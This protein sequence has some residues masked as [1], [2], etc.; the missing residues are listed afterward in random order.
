MC[1]YLGFLLPVH[2]W[3]LPWQPTEVTGGVALSGEQAFS[4]LPAPHCGVNGALGAGCSG[5]VLAVHLLLSSCH[6]PV[7]HWIF[8]THL[9]G[10]HDCADQE[11]ETMR[12]STTVP[13]AQFPWQ[14]RNPTLV[15]PL[16]IHALW[17]FALSMPFG[18][19]EQCRGR[20][21]V[22]ISPVTKM[23][24]GDL[25]S[26][27]PRALFILVPFCATFREGSAALFWRKQFQETRLSLCVSTLCN[28]KL[29]F[30]YIQKILSY[31]HS[32]EKII[33][34]GESWSKCFQNSQNL[35]LWRFVYV[36]WIFFKGMMTAYYVYEMKVGWHHFMFFL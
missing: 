21:P 20:G 19:L 34:T 2:T 28:D 35:F 1:T 14:S 16:L 23:L 17:S 18:C 26:P 15:A 29:C 3:V 7:L 13:T 8:V 25:R 27:I 31:F 11:T 12:R 4:P 36:G 24:G 33:C 22:F 10:K 9:C 5:S 30:C 32:L 6:L